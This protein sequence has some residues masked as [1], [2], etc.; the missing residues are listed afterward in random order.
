MCPHHSDSSMTWPPSERLFHN[1][2][3]LWSAQTFAVAV[4]FIDMLEQFWWHIRNPHDQTILVLTFYTYPEQ[5]KPCFKPKNLPK[6]FCRFLAT[7]S[8]SWIV[9]VFF[10]N[11]CLVQDR[12]RE[13]KL[14]LLEPSGQEDSEYVINVFILAYLWMKQQCKTSGNII[15]RNLGGGRV[16]CCGTHMPTE[17]GGI[18]TLYEMDENDRFCGPYIVTLKEF[19]THFT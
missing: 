10:N 17:V 2:D 15:S 7:E 1:K 16:E 18:A 5:S 8:Y 3:F 14:V 13:L 9:F 6:G 4:S 12:C 11:D 19:F